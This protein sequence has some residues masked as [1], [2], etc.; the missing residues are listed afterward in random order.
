MIS[1]TAKRVDPKIED[2]SVR[3]IQD[4]A[5]GFP[6]MAVLAARQKGSGKQIIRSAEQYLDRVLWGHRAPNADAQKALSILSPFDW[7][8]LGGGVSGEAAFVAERL[9]QMSFDTFVEHIKS[10]KARGVVAFRGDFVQ[11][12]PI[13]LAAR[14]A[15]RR[16]ELLPDGKL[17]AL[18]KDAPAKLQKSLLKRI[19]WLDGSCRAFLA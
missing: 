19:R 10:F 6:Q 8:G 7:V 13:P 4:L 17:F 18:F 16:L 12:Q 9:A 1:L 3:L 11:V 15:A 14:L 5:H 2:A